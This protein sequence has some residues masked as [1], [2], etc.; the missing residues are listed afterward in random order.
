MRIGEP[1]KD[2]DGPNVLLQNFKID[3]ATVTDV[4]T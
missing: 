3:N 1:G 2:N 4:R